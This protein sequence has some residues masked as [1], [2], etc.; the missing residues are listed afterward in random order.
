[1]QENRLK[2]DSITIETGSTEG[3]A[4]NKTEGKK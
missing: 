3:Y 4:N 1:M 2:K